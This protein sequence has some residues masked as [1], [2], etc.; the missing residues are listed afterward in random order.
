METILDYCD[1]HLLGRPGAEPAPMD[2]ALFLEDNR[3][4]LDP[5]FAPY[6]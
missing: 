2:G 4:R 5:L 6:L 1:L 3:E